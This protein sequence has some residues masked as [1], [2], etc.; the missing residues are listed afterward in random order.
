MRPPDVPAGQTLPANLWEWQPGMERS[1]APHVR[2]LRVL[3][4]QPHFPPCGPLPPGS[5]L[6]HLAAC[7][8]LRSLTLCHL[9]PRAL[10]EVAGHLE[11]LTALD[12]T[13]CWGTAGRG[14]LDFVTSLT[15]LQVRA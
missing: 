9:A 4:P 15:H 7:R 10:D 13:V 6:P 1:L 14:W 3:S 5:P 12:V 8:R 11:A 2:S